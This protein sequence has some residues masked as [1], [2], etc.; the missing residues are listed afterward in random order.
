MSTKI[1]IGCVP[2]H[3]SSPLYRALSAGAFLAA[4]VE[5]EIV[6]CPGGTGEVRLDAVSQFVIELSI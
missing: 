6:N 5:V 2:E 3:F 4:D 1:K